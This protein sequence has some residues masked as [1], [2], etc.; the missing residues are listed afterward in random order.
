MSEYWQQFT[1]S[2]TANLVFGALLVFIIWLKRR[3]KVSKC[4]TN[5]HWFECES[6]LDDLV[7]VTT[8]VQTQRGM[9]RDIQQMVMEFQAPNRESAIEV[10]ELQTPSLKR[11]RATSV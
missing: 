9:L 4:K 1:G 8:D 5:C 3:I 6:Q 7:K 10:I 11:A 2:S